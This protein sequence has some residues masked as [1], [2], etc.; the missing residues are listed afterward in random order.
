[1]QVLV[2]DDHPLIQE[3]LPAVLRK[4]FGEV[5]VVAAND[6]ES[7]FQRLAH[8]QAPD[9]ALLD[10]GLPGH[11]GLDTLRR[12]RWKFSSV[13]VVVVSSIDD[14]ASIRAAQGMGAVG[15]IPKTSNSVQMVAALKQIGAGGTYFPQPGMPEPANK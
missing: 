15:Y 13:P 11:A 8:H 3:I 9:L 10:L 14:P 6:L 1:M 5:E 12:F 7:A 2:V 4:A